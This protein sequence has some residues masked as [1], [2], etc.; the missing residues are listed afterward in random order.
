M[1]FV[2]QGKGSASL[3]RDLQEIPMY[4]TKFTKPLIKEKTTR[5]R[6][7][8]LRLAYMQKGFWEPS[9]PNPVPLSQHLGWM[10]ILTF[11]WAFAAVGNITTQVFSPL[12]PPHL[13][14]IRKFFLMLKQTSVIYKVPLCSYFCPLKLHR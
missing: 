6:E 12:E 2:Q 1:P 9:S 10:V 11:V 7:L 8:L 13:E 14:P 3:D 4:F 5:V